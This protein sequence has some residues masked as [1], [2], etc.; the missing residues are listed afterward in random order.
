MSLRHL[1]RK[2]AWGALGAIVAITIGVLGQLAISPWVP[3]SLALVGVLVVLMPLGVLRGLYDTY[4]IRRHEAEADE[5]AVDVAGAEPLLHALEALQASGYSAALVHNRW[6]THGTSEV[7]TSRIREDGNARAGARLVVLLIAC[8]WL[9]PSSAHAQAARSYKDVVYAT[10]DG[11]DLG[12][13][14]YLPAGVARPALLV[15]VHGGAWRSGTKAKPP[16]T[17]VQNG[18]AMASLDFRQSTDARFPAAVHDIKAA[19]RFLRAKATEYGYR[20]DRIAIA[21]SSSGGHLAVLVGVS[22]GEKEL[23]GTVGGYVSQSSDVAAIIDYYGASNLTTILAQSTPFGLNMRRPALELLLGALPD[24]APR[25]AE[26][27]SPVV[28]VDRNDPP[29]LIFHGDQ[30]PQMPINQSHELQGVYREDGP[31]RLLRRRARR[32]AR[33]GSVLR[34]RTRR[35]CGGIPAA[36]DWSMTRWAGKPMSKMNGPTACRQKLGWVILGRRKPAMNRREFVRLTGS[37][38]TMGAI[39]E[40]VVSAKVAARPQVASGKSPK[41]RMKAGT[42][43]GDSDAI[44]HAMAGFGVNHICSR[45]PSAKLDAAWSVESLTRLRERVESFGLTL[46]MV[47]LP[48]S[49]N[50]ISRSENAE[51]LLGKEPDRDRQIDD[52][53][54]MLRNVARA[55]IPSVK[56]NLTFLG[57]PRTEPTPGRGRARYSTFV[58][59]TGK[60][61]PPAD[62]RRSSRR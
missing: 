16:M 43:H 14:L 36:D 47:P 55:G 46:D 7:R 5:F 18:I 9:T 37:G 35:A 8:A 24:G 6:T 58:Y 50:E 28:H 44:L 15:W 23:E 1:R 51:I 57:V 33:R 29:L 41:A 39:A 4:V 59:A 22:N 32:G 10:V 40:Q 30:D 12:L 56:Y 38:M 34:A 17:F 27:A 53:C 3:R 52:M 25:L 54:Q 26:L 13:D 49:S 2:L 61:D 20:T 11:K 60:Q 42:Q 48:L 62:D 21:G 31:R 45:L 19:I